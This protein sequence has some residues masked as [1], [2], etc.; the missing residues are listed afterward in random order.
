MIRIS[1][2]KL[3]VDHSSGA[4]RE[5]TAKLLRISPDRIRKLEIRKQS[6]DARKKPCTSNPLTPLWI[7][8]IPS[9]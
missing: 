6:V 3:P 7:E 9:W 2:M 1:Q 4:L 8:K 5:K